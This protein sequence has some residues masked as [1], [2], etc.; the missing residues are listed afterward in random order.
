MRSLV[1]AP[2]AVLLVVVKRLVLL[3]S[4]TTRGAPVGACK[5]RPQRDRHG[6]ATQAPVALPNPLLS[7]E[8]FNARSPESP[9]F[10]GLPGQV[11][12]PKPPPFR[13]GFRQRNRQSEGVS[14][15]NPGVSAIPPGFLFGAFDRGSRIACWLASS[16]AKFMTGPPATGQKSLAPVADRPGGQARSRRP[17]RNPKHWSRSLVEQMLLALLRLVES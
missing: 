4:A 15:T 5:K 2:V 9:A 13:V 10:V 7:R 17:H 6:G 14:A 12:L 8:R 3:G 11:A 16:R 1:T